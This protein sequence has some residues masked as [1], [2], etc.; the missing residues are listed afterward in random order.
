[1]VVG[2]VPSQI[3]SAFL[4]DGGFRA[5]WGV[6]CQERTLYTLFYLI[7]CIVLVRCCNLV[8]S[9]ECNFSYVS[10][11]CQ[12]R[13]VYEC[14]LVLVL[15]AAMSLVSW[16]S[17]SSGNGSSVAGRTDMVYKDCHPCDSR[18]SVFD[19]EYETSIYI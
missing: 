3:L 1:M 13:V 4:I 5:K 9:R 2:V 17:V 14:L 10:C 16:W 8:S 6:I 18:S 12:H 11:V 7:L 15:L 19:F